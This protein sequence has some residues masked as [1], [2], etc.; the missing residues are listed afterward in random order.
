MKWKMIVGAL[1][2]SASLC[3]QS[4]AGGCGSGGCRSLAGG[5]KKYFDCHFPCGPGLTIKPIT[6]K[7]C[8]HG[9]G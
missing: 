4:F 5:L 2:V 8:H 9:C 6:L 3:S 7:R 1:I